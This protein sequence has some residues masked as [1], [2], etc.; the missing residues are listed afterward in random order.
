[1]VD[2]SHHSQIDWPTEQDL[3][4]NLH[5]MAHTNTHTTQYHDMIWHGHRDWETG[6]FSSRVYWA[7]LFFK[8]QLKP[9]L[10]PYLFPS[11]SQ[12]QISN[13]TSFGAQLRYSTCFEAW[14]KP[15]FEFEFVAKLSQPSSYFLAWA[16]TGFQKKYV[17][18]Y[19]KDKWTCV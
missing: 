8:P 6:F 14:A 5:L 1:M 3:K 19:Y 9:S 4:L 16:L 18:K 11:L 12:A 13:P 7:R 17:S 2:Q 10:R 15:G